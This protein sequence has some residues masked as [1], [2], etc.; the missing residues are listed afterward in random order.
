VHL[1]DENLRL[2]NSNVNKDSQLQTL[3]TLQDREKERRVAQ[4]EELRSQL[5]REQDRALLAVREA[6]QNA[7]KQDSLLVQVQRLEK[8]LLKKDN[9]IEE[10]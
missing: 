7:A 9:R 5:I 1:K 4:T 6:E 3:Q 8:E 10:L 2:R